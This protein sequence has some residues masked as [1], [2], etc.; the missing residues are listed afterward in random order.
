MLDDELGQVDVREPEAKVGLV[1]AVVA[2]R[3]LEG[4][5]RKSPG[6]VELLE[7]DA[8]DVAPDLEDEPLDH[9]EDVVLVDERHLDVDLRELRLPVEAQVLV[10]EALD[11][12]EVPV[13]PGDHVELLEELRALGERVELARMGPRRDEEVSGAAGR[14]LDHHRRLEL[15]KPVFVEVPPRD[16]ADP[17]AHPERLL[18][19]RAAEVEV[20]VLQALLFAGVDRVDHLERRGLA[21]VEDRELDDVDL[22]LPSGKLRVL[23]AAAALDDAAHADD[24]LAPQRSR[25][26]VRGARAVAVTAEIR[27]EDELRDALAV[28]E[29]DEDAAAVIAVARDPTEEHRL[30]AFV[31]GSELAAVVGSLQL[32]DESGH[33]VAQ[34]S[35]S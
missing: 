25:E 23:V 12:L 1:V 28:A 14:V 24:P 35:I 34:C 29:I 18:E 26:V 31:C 11:D 13:E 30:L 21:L 6:R 16:L 3:L 9:A 27:I 20:P 8:E 7:I 22:D 19:G 33:W 5:A 10:A 15:E 32:V 17:V 4:H 2:H